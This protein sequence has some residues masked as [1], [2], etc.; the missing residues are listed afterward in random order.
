[1][2]T[3]FQLSALAAASLLSL[4]AQAASWVMVDGSNSTH[5][6]HGVNSFSLGDT[7]G[8]LSYSE[9]P[10]SGTIADASGFFAYGTGQSPFEVMD[11]SDSFRADM[12]HEASGSTDFN[13]DGQTTQLRVNTL[14]DLSASTLAGNTL[15]GS[16][17]M[18]TS[19]SQSFRLIPGLDDNAA[20]PLLITFDGN[21]ERNNELG[22]S[23]IVSFSFTIDLCSADFS[24]CDPVWHESPVDNNVLGYSTPIMA[25]YDS[26]LRVT[27]TTTVGLDA[28]TS[29]MLLTAGDTSALI[30]GEQTLNFTV[31][32]VPEA[33][34]YG[35]MLAGLGLVGFMARRR[36]AG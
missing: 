9:T 2:K 34:T 24:S 11:G 5:L 6:I 30:Y 29:P 10:I 19:A 33:S 18:A 13:L 23:G 25:S 3:R 8:E 22:S 15:N 14:L 32:A 35:M 16:I 4:S 17:V 7:S 27:G 28:I 12:A 21:F 1:M 36:K 20:E 26:V 31:T